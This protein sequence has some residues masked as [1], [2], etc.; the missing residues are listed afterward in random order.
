MKIQ[1]NPYLTFQSDTPYILEHLKDYSLLSKY[2]LTNV[3]GIR[4][5][6]MNMTIPTEPVISFADLLQAGI[7]TVT[8]DPAHGE[9][10]LKS[11][12]HIGFEVYFVLNGSL[13]V[14]LE[15]HS[16][17]L[18]KY[19]AV[20]MNQNCRSLIGG[21]ENLILLTITLEKEYLK[22]HHLLNM[23][24]F[25]SYKSRYDD[26]YMDSEYVI[27]R[28]NEIPK[29]PSSHNE[30]AQ[31][32]LSVRSR[33][34][35]SRLVYQFHTELSK[36]MAG[37][38]AI[39][40]GLLTRLFYSLSNKELFMHTLVCEHNLAGE[41]LAENIKHYLDEHPQKITLDDLTGI[42]HYN[43]NYLSKVFYENMHQSIKTYNNS[44]CMQEA[45]RLLT[46]T[47]LPVSI[48]AERLGFLS[49]SQFY[50]VFQKEYGLTPNGMHKLMHPAP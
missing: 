12:K 46:E 29:E 17:D 45:K 44:I 48:I 10:P 19:D 43:R 25:L 34:D 7:V 27:L 18:C 49:R 30:N 21:G 6:L 2:A 22:K 32:M 50:K 42:F 15:E 16:Y 39:I 9:L 20:I 26:S 35:I 36:K 37:Y 31:E 11:Q 4:T 23:L 13:H 38:E 28:A 41:D 47:D 33:E 1:K 5:N 40:S 3:S 8:F 24:P 14:T